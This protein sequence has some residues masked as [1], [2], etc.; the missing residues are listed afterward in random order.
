MLVDDH[1]LFRQSLRCMLERQQQFVVVGEAKDGLEA[2]E[3]AHEM[4]PDV[5]L[6]DIRMPNCSGLCALKQIREHLPGINIVM[7]TVSEDDEDLFAAAK[8]GAKGYLLKTAEA[9]ELV[10]AV[11]HVSRGGA[12][13]SPLMAVKLLAEFAA[14]EMHEPDDFSPNAPPLTSREKEIL[15]LLGQGLSNREIATSLC[16]TESTVKSHLRNVMEKLHI[17]NR[18]Q[19]AAY[20]VRSHLA[21]KRRQTKGRQFG[22]QEGKVR[23][24]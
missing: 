1:T 6:M 17:H 7:L 10:R 23:E 3:N 20:A 2:V 16:I 4:M 21:A 24:G 12:V 8:A 14:T 13:I 5:V 15:E 18:T 19:A 9:D 11:Q 22:R